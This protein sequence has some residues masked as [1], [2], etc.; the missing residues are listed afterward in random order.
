M[1]YIILKN[2]KFHKSTFRGY[3]VIVHKAFLPR[4]R[5]STMTLRIKSKYIWQQQ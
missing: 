1:F 5:M 3:V 2:T 4:L